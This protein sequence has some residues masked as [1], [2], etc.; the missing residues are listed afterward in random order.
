MV[1][2]LLLD[3][4]Y[5]STRVPVTVYT[6]RVREGVP[7]VQSCVLVQSSTCVMNVSNYLRRFLTLDPGRHPFSFPTPTI[8]SETPSLTPSQCPPNGNSPFPIVSTGL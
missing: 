4:P 3:G 7:R 6:V 1:Q 5:H 8:P 2:E